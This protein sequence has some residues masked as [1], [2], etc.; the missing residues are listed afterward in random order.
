MDTNQK[1]WLN[2]LLA[3]TQDLSDEDKQKICLIEDIAKTRR[4]LGM[5]E[6]STEQFYYLYE[7]D[8]AI[9]WLMCY[10]F[11]SKACKQYDINLSINL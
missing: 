11:T 7:K 3:N 8:L 2:D 10:S 4:I 1:E 9:V 5:E 6:L